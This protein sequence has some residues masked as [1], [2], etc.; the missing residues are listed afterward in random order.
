MKEIEFLPQH[1]IQARLNQRLRFT[2]MWLLIVLALT[3]VCWA[4][5]SRN[6]IKV[7]GA[8]LQQIGSQ[9]LMLDAE[10]QRM[11]HLGD[12]KRLYAAQAKLVKE[13]AGNG[14]RAALVRAIAEKLPR[15]VLL[16]RLEIE[17]MMRQVPKHPATSQRPQRGAKVEMKTEK[18]DRVRVEG[19]AAD[20]LSLAR[21]LQ[22]M[23]DSGVFQQGQLAFSKDAMF[24]KMNVRVFAATFYVVPEGAEVDLM[25]LTGGMR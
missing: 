17:T 16:T 22:Q 15:Q 12:Q 10:L 7:L 11:S 20:D 9:A 4:L 23:A 19:L 3:M 14:P 21:F 18:F 1:H 5:Y 2:R 25:R 13:L 8:E 24:R 6:R